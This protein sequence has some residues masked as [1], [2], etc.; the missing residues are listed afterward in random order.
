MPTVSYATKL[1]PRE[2][3][4]SIASALIVGYGD[5]LRSDEGSAVRVSKNIFAGL[6]RL[7]HRKANVVLGKRLRGDTR[8]CQVIQFS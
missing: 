7:V 4:C 2:R 3:G 8:T 1:Q 5:C 6:L